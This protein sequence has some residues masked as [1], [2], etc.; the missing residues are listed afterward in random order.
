MQT[1]PLYVSWVSTS[2]TAQT[3]NFHAPFS[4]QQC[5]TCPNK[6]RSHGSPFNNV[7]HP[8]TKHHLHAQRALSQ[9]IASKTQRTTHNGLYL[10]GVQILYPPPNRKPLYSSINH[11]TLTFAFSL[12]IS[13]P[14]SPTQTQGKSGTFPHSITPNYLYYYTQDNNTMGS[15]SSKPSRGKPSKRS[16]PISKRNISYPQP[17]PAYGPSYTKKPPHPPLSYPKGHYKNPGPPPPPPTKKASPPSKKASF[18]L[19]PAPAPKPK[20]DTYVAP[21]MLPPAGVR[22]KKAAVP[23]AVPRVPQGSNKPRP[24]ERA[25]PDVTFTRILEPKVR[26][27]ARPGREYV[28]PATTFSAIPGIGGRILGVG[29][30]ERR[31]KDMF[32]FD[33]ERAL[34]RRMYG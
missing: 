13:N 16:K 1:I 19:Q 24:R 33:D 30:K 15:S 27:R 29:E 25:N 10:E 12:Y 32:R 14:H 6:A 9:S 2:L 21:G 26:P 28:A 23:A 34:A 8:P 17:N 31:E 11:S 4:L 18:H 7:L 3:M 5:L 20:L 22:H